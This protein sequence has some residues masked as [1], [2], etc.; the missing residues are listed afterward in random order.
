MMIFQKK[1]FTPLLALTA[2]ILGLIILGQHS[3]PASFNAKD[4][5][6]AVVKNAPE[7]PPQGQPSTPPDVAVGSSSEA[8]L[9]IFSQNSLQDQKNELYKKIAAAATH[10]SALTIKEGCAPD[11][12]VFYVARESD[13]FTIKND[14]SVTHTLSFSIDNTH[15]IEAHQEM[16]VKASFR[17]EKTSGAYG[18]GCDQ[19]P[20]PVGIVFIENNA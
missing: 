18:Y 20:K 7:N 3:K 11:P 12:F 2:V 6:S 8:L 1:L 17:P 13:M 19:S 5:K 4:Q 16:K 9:E 10:A 15:T 14:D